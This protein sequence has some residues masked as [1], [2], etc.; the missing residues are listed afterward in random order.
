MVGLVMN[1]VEGEVGD[2]LMVF[3]SGK[4]YFRFFHEQDCCET[5]QICDIAGDLED[6]VGSPILR[7]EE[8]STEDADDPEGEYR[9][10]SFTWTFYKFETVKGSVT[11]RWL[12]E[13]K[14]Y[15]SEEVTFEEV[16]V[17]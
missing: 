14:G 4:K 8:V 16:E 1:S 15:Y 11:V 10:E 7:A 9:P 6:L 17:L 3:T 5:V 12:G 2:E 13:S